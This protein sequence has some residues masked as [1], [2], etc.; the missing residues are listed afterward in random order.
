MQTGTIVVIPTLNEIGNIETLVTRLLTINNLRIVVVDDFSRDGTA[1]YL[2]A[3]VLMDPRVRVIQRPGRLGYA[4]ACLDGFRAALAWGS[5]FVVQMDADLS[6][7]PEY[8]PQFIGLAKQYDVIQG[9]RYVAGGRTIGWGYLRQILSKFG[10]AYAR[11]LL[12]L[13][14]RDCTGGYRLYRREVLASMH[15]NT[16][17]SNGYAF[18]IEMLYRCQKDYWRITEVPIWFRD[19]TAGK[20]K[21][22]LRI[23]AEAAWRVPMIRLWAWSGSS[24][25]QIV[26]SR[27]L[28]TFS[29]KGLGDETESRHRGGGGPSAV[30][31]RLSLWYW[32][33]QVPAKWMYSH[34]LV[35][36][37]AGRIPFLRFLSFRS[38]DGLTFVTGDAGLRIAL[39]VGAYEHAELSCVK[40]YAR[41]GQHVVEI[42]GGLGIVSCYIARLIGETGRLVTVEPDPICRDILKWNLQRNG[43]ACT[44][45]SQALGYT[46]QRSMSTADGLR[47]S[48]YSSGG[49]R[50]SVSCCTLQAIL[51]TND[52][53]LDMLV[54]D[55]EGI[56]LELFAMESSV[57]RAYSPTIIAEIHTELLRMPVTRIV[58]PLIDLGYRVDVI[59]KN[60]ETSIALC[61]PPYRPIRT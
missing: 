30:T 34:K 27:V 48:F 50:F 56:E 32:C 5:E 38:P 52:M 7:D 44:V 31:Q 40:V 13:P 59:S 29:Q 36:R 41:K 16:V 19:R 28:G 47:S 54:L 42:G 61:H 18:Q 15:L 10:N 39:S 45:L 26:D 1:E 2:A 25:V 17:R 53:R 49:K 14:V 12:K 37:L 24:S 33:L 20:S 8:L 6:H 3:L 23:V 22:S 57:L 46:S 55:A 35:R 51:S 21:M 60:I 11:F 58:E 43:L 9:S 4:S